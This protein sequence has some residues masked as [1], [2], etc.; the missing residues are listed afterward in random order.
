MSSI[1]TIEAALTGPG[2]YFEVRD[3]D[4]LGERMAV[5]AN[6]PPSLRALVERSVAFGDRDHL[7]FGDRRIGFA[8]H[9][10]LVASVA[11]GLEARFGVKK[12]D[13]VAILAANCPEWILTF[14]AAVS[15]G[16]V[17][18]GMN[19]WWA[20]GEIVAGLEL[21]DPTVLVADRK[22]LDRLAPGD[23]RVPVVC[24]EDDFA[25]LLAAGE[26]ASLSGVPLH[27]DDPAIVL[28]TSGT[29]G[30]A[31]AVVHTHRNALALLG[32]QSF[33]G[34]R[35]FAQA[36]LGPPTSP[37]VLLA[38]NPL[39]HVS[40]LHSGVIAQLAVGA[41]GVWTT[42]RFDPGVVLDLIARER[43]TGWAPHGS[44]GLRVAEHPDV[45][46][47]DLSCVR[48][49]G[50]GG[51]PVTPEIQALYRATFPAARSALTVGYGLTEATALATMAFGDELERHPESV[52][53]P[54]PTVSVEIRDT[55][56]RAVASGEE[57]DI[58]LRSPLV[59]REYFRAPS[60]TAACIGPGRW[61]RTGDVGRIE[62]GRLYIA[63]RKRDLI[64]RGAENVYPAEI[65]RRLLAHPA[66]AEAAVIG[67]PSRELGQEVKAVLVP[68]PGADL[69]VAELSR[70]VADALAYF[71]VPAHWEVR[72]EPLPRNATGKVMKVAL[73]T[74]TDGGMVQ[75]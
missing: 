32:L 66:V 31:K 46:R 16:A 73:E 64:L 41:R 56:G 27:E 35:L 49:I 9:H 22:R 24:I 11:R 74:G 65:E 70:W 75:E 26:G 72:R 1:E 45:A 60:E 8:E 23:T 33:H 5:F 2:A 28:F 13:R 50:S 58:T 15:L 59:M 3:E 18:T 68:R 36:G 48:T 30:R 17:A 20:R 40:G 44:M 38:T 57:G 7:V 51:A 10:R 55:D 14:W 4:V 43:V 71:K 63:T 69:D 62:D 37:P 39:F 25:A 21:S 52:G 42:G 29:T 19:A 12:G 47:Y 67:V 54:L 34:A 6:R 53:R 61:L